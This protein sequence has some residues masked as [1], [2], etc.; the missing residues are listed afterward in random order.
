M[1]GSERLEPVSRYKNSI[2]RSA[3]LDVAQNSRPDFSSSSL[4]NSF[5]MIERYGD[6]FLGLNLH[7]FDYGHRMYLIGML[8]GYANNKKLTPNTR[9]KLSYDLLS[10]TK[11][12]SNLS[13]PCIKRYLFEQVRSKFIEVTPDEWDKAC[14][15][16]VELFVEKK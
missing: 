11:T 2:M 6:G 5:D 9:L 13:K 8:S 16:P 15:L 7:Y 10:S 4:D 12:M 14:A 3:L 1:R